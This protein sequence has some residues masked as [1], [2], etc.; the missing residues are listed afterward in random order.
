[1][2]TFDD[3][4]DVEVREE[5]QVQK[6]DLEKVLG[7]E[8]EILETYKEDKR[9]E[10]FSGNH[11]EAYQLL[12]KTTQEKVADIK[13]T[14]KLLQEYIDA[15]ENTELNTESIIR[16]MYSAALLERITTKTPKTHTIID[17][18]GKTFNYLFYYVYNVKNLTLTNIKGNLILSYAGSYG[19]N[20]DYLTLDRIEGCNLL[21]CAA[22]Y[23][24]SAT[25][26]TLSDITGNYAVRTI[27]W[28]GNAKNITLHNIKGDHAL[29]GAG[30]KSGSVKNITLL[31]LQGNYTLENAG[32]NKG[33]VKNITLNNI[34]GACTLHAA[35]WN[36]G[37]V[38]NSLKE[39]ELNKKQRELISK[40]EKIVETIHFL[41]F[42]EQT[43]AHDEIARLQEEIFAGEK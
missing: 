29:E 41:S 5:R 11:F 27:G 13:I 18:R 10:N 9:F 40:I 33:S 32:S 38:E 43:K 4:K 16:G 26:I 22:S 15:R 31:N 37:C 36:Y 20:I 12:Y 35:G 28:K 30:T 14:P 8:K 23:S 25:H 34:Q 21:E 17:G 42:E 6:S 7:V 24:G 19:G 1:M 39:N 2:G 3:F